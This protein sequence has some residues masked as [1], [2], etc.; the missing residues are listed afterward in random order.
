MSIRFI[1]LKLE[2]KPSMQKFKNIQIFCINF[3]V[4]KELFFAVQLY[5]SSAIYQ[6]V[7]PSL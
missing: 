7:Y 6:G 3:T 1:I 5:C 2:T 4:D